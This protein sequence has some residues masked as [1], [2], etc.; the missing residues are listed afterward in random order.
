MRRHRR[1]AGK[2]SS[3][4]SS[5]RGGGRNASGRS[6]LDASGTRPGGNTCRSAAAAEESPYHTTFM[7]PAANWRARVLDTDSVI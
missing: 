5:R 2:D 7:R 1:G 4:S 3:T 6:G